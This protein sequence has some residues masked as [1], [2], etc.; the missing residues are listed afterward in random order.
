[1]AQVLSEWQQFLQWIQRE[2]R[3][4]S[5]RVSYKRPSASQLKVYRSWLVGVGVLTLVLWHWKLAL[6]LGTGG[7]AMFVAYSS[8]G[9]NWQRIR[10]WLDR[11]WDR[12]NRQ[13]TLTLASG[14]AATLGTYMVLALWTG[15]ENHALAIAIVLQ[16]MATLAVLGLLVRAELTRRSSRRYVSFDRQLDRL[17]DTDPLVR[18]IAVRQILRLWQENSL[19]PTHRKAA[20]DAFRLMLRREPE[21]LVRNSVLEGLKAM[22][23]LKTLTSGTPPISIP[24]EKS[25]SYQ[26]KDG[27]LKASVF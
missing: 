19:E 12:Q 9:W 4:R 15:M 8:Q 3:V 10:N 22:G 17:T 5:R 26:K 13:F 11:L 2:L 1:M 14:G 16:G 20:A 21:S 6:S 25:K 27:K 7:L 23:E 18:A 24:V